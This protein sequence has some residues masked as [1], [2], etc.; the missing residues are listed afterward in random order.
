MKCFCVQCLKPFEG[1]N[2]AQEFCSTEHRLEFGKAAKR[3]HALKRERLGEYSEKLPG[4]KS[5]PGG[6]QA[7][8]FGSHDG[9][10]VNDYSL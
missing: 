7:I 9:M 1:R 4:S 8:N 5:V 2:R 10:D 6:R 3:A